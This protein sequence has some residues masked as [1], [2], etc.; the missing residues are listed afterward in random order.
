MPVVNDY[1]NSMYRHIHKTKTYGQNSARFINMIRLLMEDISPKSIL[2]YGCGQSRLADLMR[3]HSNAETH[4]YDPAID[5]INSIPL[6]KY[7]FITCTDVMEHVVE[8]DCR[9]VIG[10]LAALSGNVFFHISTRPAGEILPDGQNAHCTVRNTKWWFG[11]IT[12]YFPDA[13]VIFDEYGNGCG[14]ITWKSAHKYIFQEIYYGI[15]HIQV[16]IRPE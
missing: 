3:E 9:K 8:E 13:E 5:G 15:R 11:L 7:D 16:C 4:R 1:L 6:D 2:D 12:E 10:E 14:I